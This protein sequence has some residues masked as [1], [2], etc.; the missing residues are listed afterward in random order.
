MKAYMKPEI[1][2]VELFTQDAISLTTVPKTVY[3]RSA[4]KGGNFVADDELIAYALQQGEA[5]SGTAM[6]ALEW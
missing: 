4:A 2:E 1:A 3:R 5:L 6:G